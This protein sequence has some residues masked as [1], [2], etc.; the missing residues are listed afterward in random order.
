MSI[1]P[2][3]PQLAVG[4]LA[5]KNHAVLLIRRGK[6]PNQGLWSLPGGR[7]KWG[8]TLEAALQREVFE[9]T[10]VHIKPTELVHH[11]D[12]IERDVNGLIHYHYVIL[13]YLVE[14]LSGDPHA[15][16]DADAAQWVQLEQLGFLQCVAGI[17]ELINH[18]AD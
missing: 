5:L 14:T 15:G 11:A 13:D 8:E 16:S 9:E 18:Y 2:S 1:I 10:A 7:V 17:R 6:A 4:A 3:G 12:L